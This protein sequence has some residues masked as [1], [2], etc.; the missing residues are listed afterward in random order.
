MLN[1]AQLASIAMGFA[2]G[3]VFAL[4]ILAGDLAARRFVRA[5][6]LLDAVVRLSVFGVIVLGTA[7]LVGSFFAALVRQNALGFWSSF[8]VGFVLVP[9]LVHLHLRRIERKNAG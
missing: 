3:L 5:S 8:V 7:E 1:A 9:W 2:V 4:A 6:A